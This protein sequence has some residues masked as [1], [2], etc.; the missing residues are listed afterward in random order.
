MGVACL[1]I[2]LCIWLCQMHIKNWWNKRTQFDNTVLIFDALFSS[3]NL[4]LFTLCA[5]KNCIFI[6]TTLL[7]IYI[8][9][10]SKEI[11][12]KAINTTIL[13]PHVHLL[14]DDAACIAYVRLTQYIDKWVLAVLQTIHFDYTI[15][16]LHTF[17]YR[18]RWPGVRPFTISTFSHLFLFA[19]FPFYFHF[20]FIQSIGQ[21]TSCDLI[22]KCAINNYGFWIILLL[23]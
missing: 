19:F 1:D 15:C 23:F 6:I 5:A 7:G 2:D 16:R 9:S 18:N 14:G 13:N 22:F 11:K 17:I 4:Y 8:F 20:D 3:R 10:G 21:K 12:I